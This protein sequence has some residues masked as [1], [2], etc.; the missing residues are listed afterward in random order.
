MLRE[1]SS[2]NLKMQDP[3]RKLDT[4]PTKTSRQLHRM[5]IAKLV[6]RIPDG[7]YVTTQFGK[8]VL[9][10]MSSIEFAFRNKLYFLEHDVWQL[11][12]SFINRLGELSESTLVTELPETM[13]EWE[14]MFRNAAEYVWVI[15]PQVMPSLSQIMKDRL[16]NG[17]RLRTLALEN[18]NPSLKPYVL[19]G[20]NVERR[21]LSKVPIG[22]V[23]TE[24]EAS[25]CL[26]QVDGEL[27]VHTFFGKDLLFREWAKE[28]YLYYWSKADIWF[29]K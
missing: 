7:T 11:P 25:F 21:T 23:I 5:S 26:P 29:P 15:T 12:S 3:A 22:M 1:L 10:L 28:L 6:E 16:E 14:T 2:S 8:L 20:Q 9:H 4:T 27:I 13:L 18:Q 24:K 19:T 17:V